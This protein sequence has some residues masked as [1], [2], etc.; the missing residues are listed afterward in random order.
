MKWRTKELS[1]V[2][3]ANDRVWIGLLKDKEPERLVVVEFNEIPLD[4]SPP[5]VF[6]KNS[7]GRVGSK[8][9]RKARLVR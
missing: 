8:G 5:E 9:V 4:L 3:N 1:K 7:S 6:L 2:N